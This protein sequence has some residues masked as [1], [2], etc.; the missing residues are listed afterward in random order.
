M[1]DATIPYSE[2]VAGLTT[3]PI[4]PGDTLLSIV[5][6]VKARAADGQIV[7]AI[8]SGGEKLSAE[9]TLGAFIGFTDSIRRDLADDWEGY[10]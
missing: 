7:W 9:E 2:L 3:A 1:N 4:E 6:L 10:G 8:R 5:S